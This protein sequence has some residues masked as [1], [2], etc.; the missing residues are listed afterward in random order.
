VI[1]G[2]VGSG[3][4]QTSLE[5]ICPRPHPDQSASRDSWCTVLTPTPFVTIE[6]K[7]TVIYPYAARDQDEM[8]LERG[9]VV[10]VLQKNLEGWWKIRYLALWLDRFQVTHVASHMSLHTCL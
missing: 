8:N 7:Y 5:E 2:S 3:D 1:L 9:A 10:E 4:A 6:E